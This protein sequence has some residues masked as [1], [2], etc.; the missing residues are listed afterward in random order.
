[1]RPFRRDMDETHDTAVSFRYFTIVEAEA[2]RAQQQQQQS[3][4]PSQV[5]GA[6]KAGTDRPVQRPSMAGETNADTGN[7]IAPRDSEGLA[8][9]S[10]MSEDQL[11]RPDRETK[12]S[13]ETTPRG[14]RRVTFDIKVETD[15]AKLTNHIKSPSVNVQG[16]H[17]I[18]FFLDIFFHENR[19][20]Q[21]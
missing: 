20:L 5:A 6:D 14:K 3:I 21:R 12:A 10:E 9:A 2:A 1:M 19:Y 7:E 11:S 15:G 17:Y 8:E 13:M 4:S 18:L 16:M